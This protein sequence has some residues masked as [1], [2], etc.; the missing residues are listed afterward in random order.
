MFRNPDD[1]INLRIEDEM[2]EFVPD[3]EMKSVIL[4]HTSYRLFYIHAHE[5]V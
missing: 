1:V 4:K 5:E 3:V 2:H